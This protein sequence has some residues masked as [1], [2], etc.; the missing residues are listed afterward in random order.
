VIIPIRTWLRRA[1]PQSRSSAFQPQDGLD[2]VFGGANPNPERVGCPGDRVIRGA[3]RGALPLNH[4]AY[5][6][7]ASCSEC[8]RESRAWHASR[9][10][11]FRPQP[12]AA[13]AA[14]LILVAGGIYVGRNRIAGPSAGVPKEVVLDYQNEGVS[15]SES[16]DAAR[17]MRTLP[18]GLFDLTLLLP[19]GSEAGRYEFRLLR[20]DGKAVISTTATASMKDFALR[21]HIGLDLR[22]V[23]PGQ[24]TVQTRRAG[25]DWDSHLVV[26]E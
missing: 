22:S 17:R 16:G 19:T 1:M 13:A 24:Y 6:H 20:S 7:L 23:E 14:V 18:P 25:E 12:F 26:V 15:R 5:D 2:V 4:P 3:A 8:Y 11:R 10:S 9:K 21:L